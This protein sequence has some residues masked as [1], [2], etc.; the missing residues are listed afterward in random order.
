LSADY[1]KIPENLEAACQHVMTQCNL[2]G[3]KVEIPEKHFP[4][5]VPSPPPQEQGPP[6]S[7]SI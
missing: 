3:I 2:Q 1:A 6:G 7:E 4:P 5:V